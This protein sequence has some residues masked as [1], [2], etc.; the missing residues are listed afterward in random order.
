MPA[1]ADPLLDL[2]DL[3]PVG[4]L[5]D[6]YKTLISDYLG[7]PQEPSPSPPP[8]PSYTEYVRRPDRQCKD[9]SNDRDTLTIRLVGAHPLWGHYLYDTICWCQLL[10]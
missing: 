9:A 1:N 6:E 7:H 10:Y 4:A 5:C 8:Q 3:F 2:A